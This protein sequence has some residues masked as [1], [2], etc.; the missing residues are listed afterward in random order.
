MSALPGEV[1]AVAD[2]QPSALTFQAPCVRYLEKSLLSLITSRAPYHC[3]PR[4][5][6]TLRSRCCR[7]FRLRQESCRRRSLSRSRCRCWA[8][9]RCSSVFSRMRIRCTRLTSRPYSASRFWWLL[10]E[11][12]SD[13]A[14]VGRKSKPDPK[15]C[16]RRHANN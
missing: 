6:V 16:M 10:T 2:Y 11:S 15:K 4:A 5:C 8:V 7:C 9:I 14:C 13:D 3:K 1:A 12:R